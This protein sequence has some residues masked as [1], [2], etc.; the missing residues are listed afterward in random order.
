[1]G[2]RAEFA[3]AEA[4]TEPPNSES[5][6]PMDWRIRA[7]F[8]FLIAPISLGLFAAVFSDSF[9]ALQFSAIVGYPI[10]IVVGL[11]FF[12]ISK[13]VGWTGLWSYASFAIVCASVLV[14]AFVIFPALSRSESAATLLGVSAYWAQSLLAVIASAFSVGVFWLVA[15]PDRG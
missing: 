14:G 1:M 6:R 12:I 13:L 5:V 4:V 8:A 3:G 7:L 9:W 2:S 10:A 11:P 15:R